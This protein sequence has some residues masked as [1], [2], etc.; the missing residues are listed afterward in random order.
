MIGRSRWNGANGDCALRAPAGR[1]LELPAADRR[2]A[3][4]SVHSS[5][6]EPMLLRMKSRRDQ[7][8]AGGRNA[9]RTDVIPVPA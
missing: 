9:S 7:A 2:R 4:R 3:R 8:S 1:R 5:A 6:N